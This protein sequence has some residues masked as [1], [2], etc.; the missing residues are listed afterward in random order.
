MFEFTSSRYASCGLQG[1]WG[2]RTSH[3]IVFFFLLDEGTTMV[4]YG[5]LDEDAGCL[6]VLLTCW[7]KSGGRN[8]CHSS[9]QEVTFGRA[10][11]FVYEEP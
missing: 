3:C 4:F 1:H 2:K 11:C 10:M 6:G 5:H 8:K 7:G 9:G